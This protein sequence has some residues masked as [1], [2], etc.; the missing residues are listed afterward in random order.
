MRHRMIVTLIMLGLWPL[1]VRATSDN[2][3]EAAGSLPRVPCDPVPLSGVA[4]PDVPFPRAQRS[5]SCACP[6]LECPDGTVEPCEADCFLSDVAECRCE[7]WCDA[8]GIP[9]GS[10]VCE[11]R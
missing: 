9:R 3:A 4:R 7:A 5:P 2:V 6:P 8:D 10:S 11:C 1:L